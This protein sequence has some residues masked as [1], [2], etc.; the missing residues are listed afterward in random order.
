MKHRWPRGTIITPNK[1]ER[2]CLNGCGIVKVTRHETEGAR[3]VHWIEFW[4]GLDRIEGKGTPV[5]ESVNSTAYAQPSVN[6][7]AYNE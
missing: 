7:G 4:R 6:H 2:E 3:E 1:T 5:C